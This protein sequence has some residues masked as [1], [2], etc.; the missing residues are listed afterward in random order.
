MLNFCTFL[1]IF[2]ENWEIGGCKI[3]SVFFSHFISL[4]I[5]TSE[6]AVRLHLAQH[7]HPVMTWHHVTGR[8]PIAAVRWSRSRPAVFYAV[9][10]GGTLR[11]YDLLVDDAEP[12][13]VQK[14]GL[15][16]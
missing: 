2:V 1:Q 6:G 4:Q 11:V 16:R 10:A 9:D 13:I 15:T 14:T 3:F 8:Q 12:V 7:E 5:S